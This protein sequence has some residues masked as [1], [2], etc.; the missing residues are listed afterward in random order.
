MR[1]SW[2]G[3]NGI[4]G[5]FPLLRYLLRSFASRRPILLSAIL[6]VFLLGFLVPFMSE[7]RARW[8]VPYE[9][10]PERQSARY[11][12][13]GSTGGGAETTMS[14]FM[15]AFM[16][17]FLSLAAPHAQGGRSF[18][19]LLRAGFTGTRCGIAIAVYVALFALPA[20]SLYPLVL[21]TA[22]QPIR[23][24]ALAATVVAIPVLVGAL[25]GLLAASGL[26][27]M[28]KRPLSFRE[29]LRGSATC[30]SL[31]FATV[32]ALIALGRISLLWALPS[33]AAVLLLLLLGLGDTLDRRERR[34][35]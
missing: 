24:G 11:V 3:S 22:R 5:T 17:G 26:F 20:V 9:E 32:A 21:L 7:R 18:E 23:I 25:M 4:S 31:V 15:L 19:A 27:R 2:R 6:L 12:A 10:A 8:L 30:G 34:A 14:Y 33:I 16:L 1:L 35:P 29:R 28:L 13:T